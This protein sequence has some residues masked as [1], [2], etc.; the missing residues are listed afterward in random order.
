MI[1]MDSALIVFTKNAL[2]GKVKT[3]LAKTVGD[4]NAL[5]IYNELLKFTKTLI[6]KV[7]TK[8]LIFY[9]DFVDTN[10]IFNAVVFEK[11]CQ[12]GNDLGERMLNA[13]K[14]TFKLGY[15]RAILIGSDCNELTP[16]VLEH[17]IRA[18]DEND[19]VIGPA[20]DGGYYLIGM[21]KLHPKLFVYKNWSTPTVFKEAIFEAKEL[22]FKYYLLPVLSDIDNEQDLGNLSKL[23]TTDLNQNND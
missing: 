6:L 19:L 18:L 16:E 1:S 11:Y 3:R 9:S 5:L 12:K 2:L 21:K 22:N 17:A 20:K 8:K 14:V 4:K 7:K 15:E 23:I 10:D 13:F